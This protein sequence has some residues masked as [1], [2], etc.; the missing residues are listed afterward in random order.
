VSGRTPAE[1]L[2]GFESGEKRYSHSSHYVPVP[3]LWVLGIV[4]NPAK[5]EWCLGLREEFEP[6]AVSCCADWA[7][8][9]GPP[10]SSWSCFP[11]SGEVIFTRHF[12]ELR[13]SSPGATTSVKACF[14]Q[15]SLRSMLSCALN[16]T[17]ASRN[18]PERAHMLHAYE[19]KVETQNGYHTGA[20]C[21][22]YCR[23]SVG[24]ELSPER[25]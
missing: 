1:F 18:D 22:N 14:R 25:V 12:A 15:P 8:A 10:D 3:K 17:S 4:R 9:D 6:T 24:C 11:N 13:E 19:L 20:R 23:T 5:P 2:D 16:Q 21:I 7:W